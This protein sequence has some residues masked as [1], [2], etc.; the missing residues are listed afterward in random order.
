MDIVAASGRKITVWIIGQ[1]THTA[2]PFLPSS[3]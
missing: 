1:A 2:P 3:V